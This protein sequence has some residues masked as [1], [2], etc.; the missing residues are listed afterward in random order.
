M[1]C[2]TVKKNNKVLIHATMCE[3]GKHKLS[4]KSH[5][6]K[7]T[8]DPVYRKYPKQ[9][10]PQRQHASWRLPEQGGEEGEAAL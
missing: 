7:V 9:E 6:Q 8:Y 2:S 3:T 1:D 4:E 5:I 10:D